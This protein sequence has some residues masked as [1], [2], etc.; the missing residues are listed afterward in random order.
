MASYIDKEGK[1][2]FV[3]PPGPE[4]QNKKT[5]LVFADEVDSEP[6]YDDLLEAAQFQCAVCK[7]RVEQVR[8]HRDPGTSAKT[9]RFI[10]HG[11]EQRM[12]ISDAMLGR[13]PTLSQ[14]RPFLLDIKEIKSDFGSPGQIDTYIGQRP[15]DDYLKFAQ[16]LLKDIQVSTGIPLRPPDPGSDEWRAWR[17]REL[18]WG[19]P[20][21]TYSSSS[22]T[23]E[24]PPKPKPSLRAPQSGPRKIILED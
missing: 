22:S 24:P 18:Q 23:P 12:P 14:I 17:S 15:S 2:V 3:N 19:G 5:G 13:R 20:M 11:R 1:L 8:L 9:L 16:S 7:K 21:V 6:N 10:C 4:I